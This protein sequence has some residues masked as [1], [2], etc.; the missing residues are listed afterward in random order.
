M[1]TNLDDSGDWRDREGEDHANQ[2]AMLNAV[3]AS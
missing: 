3:C 2:K 1:G